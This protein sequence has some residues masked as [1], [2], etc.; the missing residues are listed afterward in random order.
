MAKYPKFQQYKQGF[1][2]GEDI[3][4]ELL[5]MA[6]DEKIEFEEEQYNRSKPLISF[7]SRRLSH[8]ISMIWRSTSRL[9]MMIIPSY[10]KALQII[11]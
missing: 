4:E 5:K 10:Q 2:V 8:G 11:K 6:G 1:V 9:S 3:M 7:R